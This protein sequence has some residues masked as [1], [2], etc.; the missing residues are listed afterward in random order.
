MGMGRTPN[1]ANGTLLKELA[2]KHDLTDPF[3][4]LF[5]TKKS[6]SYLPFGNTRQNKSRLD[7]F[8][9][10]TALLSGIHDVGVFPSKLSSQFDHKPVFLKIN[11]QKKWLLR[12]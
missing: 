9:V 8:V 1:K 12:A 4:V 6:F 3:R 5:P 2:N 10:S 11:C 7:F